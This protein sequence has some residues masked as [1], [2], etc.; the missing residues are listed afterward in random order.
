MIF[1]DFSRVYPHAQ[2]SAVLS[3]AGIN[4]F[5][6]GL[7]N[8]RVKY[9]FDSG[10]VMVRDKD[11]EAKFLAPNPPEQILNGYQEVKLVNSA[12]IVHTPGVPAIPA[13]P[14][15][16]GGTIRL[17]T[18]AAK[19]STP[20]TPVATDGTNTLDYDEETDTFVSIVYDGTNISDASPADTGTYFLSGQNWQ[21]DW[22]AVNVATGPTRFDPT[23]H[24]I[25][26]T[27][28]TFTVAD[29]GDVTVYTFSNP[30]TLT[31]EQRTLR[32]NEVLETS[33]SG[34]PRSTGSLTLFTEH[35]VVPPGRITG[36]SVNLYTRVNEGAFP[37][38]TPSYFNGYNTVLDYNPETDT[39]TS[40]RNDV[41]NNTNTA[42]TPP[43]TGAIEADSSGDNN[44]WVQDWT[45]I[46]A[47]YDGATH[48][49]WM[50][51]LEF[52]VAANGDVTIT[53][54]DAPAT[55]VTDAMIT[56]NDAEVLNTTNNGHPRSTGSL[57]E[58][59]AVA[60]IDHT[61]T[62]AEVP[63]V[64]PI[65]LVTDTGIPI[66]ANK[67]DLRFWLVDTANSSV[68]NRESN[69]NTTRDIVNGLTADLTVGDDEDDVKA[70]ADTAYVSNTVNGVTLYIGKI[71]NNFGVLVANN[72]SNKYLR[73]V[74]NDQTLPTYVEKPTNS[75]FS[76]FNPNNSVFMRP[77]TGD[78]MKD[79]DFLGFL[80]G[81]NNDWIT[82]LPK[83]QDITLPSYPDI[84][85]NP[86][87]TNFT[88]NIPRYR[89]GSI[90]VQQIADDGT[91]T[92]LESFAPES[93]RRG[94]RTVFVG[95][96]PEQPRV[97]AVPAV[98]PVYEGSVVVK[99]YR[100]R[101]NST[102]AADTPAPNYNIS[103]NLGT[104]ATDTNRDTLSGNDLDDRRATSGALPS[105][106]AT[107]PISSISEVTG[108]TMA[109]ELSDVQQDTGLSVTQLFTGSLKFWL[110]DTAVTTTPTRDPDINST[111]EELVALNRQGSV[112]GN[113]TD[114]AESH[115]S[116][117]A[118]VDGQTVYIALTTTGIL[119]ALYNGNKYLRVEYLSVAGGNVDGN[120]YQDYRGERY[121]RTGGYD[122]ARH[123][124][125]EATATFNITDTAAG[126]GTLTDFT[127]AEL[128]PTQIA[129]YD[130]IYAG[131]GDGAGNNANQ[132]SGSLS[133]FTGYT[134]T[135]EV[136][137]VPEI[138]YRPADPG[139]PTEVDAIITPITGGTAKLFQRVDDGDSPTAAPTAATYDLISD[140]LSLTGGA[141]WDQNFDNEYRNYE[142]GTHDIHVIE[143]PFTVDSDT[144][145]A[146]VSSIGAAAKLDEPDE[147]LEQSNRFLTPPGIT[148]SDGSKTVYAIPSTDVTWEVLNGEL[149]LV[150][151][152][153]VGFDGDAHFNTGGEKVRISYQEE[154]TDERNDQLNYYHSLGT[155]NKIEQ[156]KR[157]RINGIETLQ[158]TYIDKD[159]ESRLTLTNF[160]PSVGWSE[161]DKIKPGK[162]G[163]IT[164]ASNDNEAIRGAY[165]VKVPTPDFP[166]LTI[167]L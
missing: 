165:V 114:L 141:G 159:S 4:F 89:E 133:D 129:D 105:V 13:R 156:A 47:G 3:E 167:Q 48:D 112:G 24:D 19:G 96:T 52:T 149:I 157:Q 117:Q 8:S 22:T 99:L 5:T 102:S 57:T 72:N 160:D 135:P 40:V 38:A 93:T 120:W 59:T 166:Y 7:D 118:T 142:S 130:V 75:V 63:A 134:F 146:T 152:E 42:L 54:I 111:V 113:T 108:F 26:E 97:P 67:G 2:R 83:I 121:T 60:P 56:A 55:E 11:A 45:Q 82:E 1:R 9:R 49:V 148:R 65:D 46:M 124:L 122:A 64:A 150:T 137:M 30:A 6:A 77:S 36:G 62:I 91:L 106:N 136:P 128:T 43:S 61:R 71:G 51:S 73:I 132:R 131:A 37:D 95:G 25:W 85:N 28:L 139:T 18:Q 94:T 10:T 92:S 14:G 164:K 79:G 39:F 116:L 88:I 15:L 32:D 20:P 125:Y 44:I 98:P 154:V 162:E 23:T 145:D 144:G 66:P 12:E 119:T 31:A 103:Y 140:T 74:H 107:G 50:V 33:N 138:P 41:D 84:T 104:G 21:Q 158:F 16:A 17:Y 81:T 78:S 100:R 68:P 163:R 86:P 70:L 27:T 123:H 147:V 53:A 109:A 127:V 126:T 58:F 153:D 34:Y 110:E 161:N 69:L 155:D 143:I 80:W 76:D 101:G 151:V 35:V 90:G 87:T 115:Q 29:N